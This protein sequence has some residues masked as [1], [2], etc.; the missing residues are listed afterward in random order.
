MK[1]NHKVFEL[2]KE[3][4]L[5]HNPINIVDNYD[6]NKVSRLT[7][8]IAFTNGAEKALEL[9]DLSDFKPTKELV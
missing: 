2:A 5:K 6:L 4:A 8:Q 7:A 9:L 3:Y 1:I